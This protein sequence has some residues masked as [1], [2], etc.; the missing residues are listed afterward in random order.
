VVDHEWN[1]STREIVDSGDYESD[2][3]VK[4]KT[5]ERSFEPALKG[6]QAEGAAC[7]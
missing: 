4:E 2:E 7:D 1:D 5:E 6:A 3:K